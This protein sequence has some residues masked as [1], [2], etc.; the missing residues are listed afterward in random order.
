M[1]DYEI[2]YDTSYIFYSSDMDIIY[3]AGYRSPWPSLGSL[4]CNLNWVA[5]VEL[6]VGEVMDWDSGGQ[7]IG[8]VWLDDKFWSRDF[9]IKDYHGWKNA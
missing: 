5:E 2:N 4:Y 6:Y 8:I 9:F 7:G 3:V 1:I